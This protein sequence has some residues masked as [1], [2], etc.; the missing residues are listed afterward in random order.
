MYLKRYEYEFLMQERNVQLECDA[1]GMAQQIDGAHCF[2][3]GTA[4]IVPS[5]QP[6]LIH[7][8]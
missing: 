8:G 3:T 6:M 1:I 7:G 5:H 4:I 2:V